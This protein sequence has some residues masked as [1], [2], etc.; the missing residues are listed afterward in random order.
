MGDKRVVFEC[1]EWWQ[2][3]GAMVFQFLGCVLVRDFTY[4][5]EVDSFF[6]QRAMSKQDVYSS[7]CLPQG[8]AFF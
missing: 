2:H 5:E 6:T 7:L 3:F 8:G 4:S 1:V